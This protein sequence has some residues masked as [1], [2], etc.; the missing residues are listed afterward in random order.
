MMM[1]MMMMMMKTMMMMLRREDAGEDDDKG[2]EIMTA[3]AT[4][5]VMIT[6]VR[7]RRWRRQL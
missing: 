3:M 2:I 6:M 7:H 1:K 4:T 5:I